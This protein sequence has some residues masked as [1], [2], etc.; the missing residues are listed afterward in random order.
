MNDVAIYLRKSRDEENL[1]LEV[2]RKHEK[3]L[4]D[5]ANTRGFRIVKIY[6]EVVSGESLK[7]RF[8]MQ[9]LLVAISEEA[10]DA[11]LVT[12]IS[13]LGRGDALEQ[14]IIQNAFA[15][16]NTRIIT[17]N[18]E[19]NPSDMDSEMIL[20]FES[21]LARQELRL[22][23]QRMRAGKSRSASLG[24]WANGIPP[25]G[26]TYNPQ[27]KHLEIN[28]EQ[29]EVVRQCVERCL[30]GVSSTKIA[31]GLNQ[32]GIKTNKGGLWHENSVRRMLVNPIYTGT[33]VFNKSVW[34]KRAMVR[35]LPQ[36]EW[37]VTDNAHPAIIPKKDQ[38]RVLATFSVR[39]IVPHAARASKH[40]L[41]GIVTCG[42]CGRTHSLQ[43]RVASVYDIKPCPRYDLT[44]G[45]RC[46][47]MSVNSNIILDEIYK[48][49]DVFEHELL[50]NKNAKTS[51]TKQLEKQLER[52]E[53]ELRKVQGTFERLQEMYEEGDINRATYIDRKEKRQAEIQTLQKDIGELARSINSV[54]M[55]DNNE[56]L[57]RI[58]ELKQRWN[59]SPSDEVNQL[60]HAILAKVSYVRTE[61]D[62]IENITIEYK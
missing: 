33:M 53:K 7:Q 52:K 35:E 20:S 23:K 2:L 15:E 14:A 34:K 62:T 50:T 11:V 39:A 32:Q 19:Y 51:P 13:R 36:S 56:R 29:A 10:Y 55:L 47:N 16:T 28:E 38:E 45:E 37:I 48:Q 30:Q 58:V 1:G 24:Q 3:E 54:S 21:L 59:S 43:K 61:R 8:A 12:E 46:P 60:L 41:S 42:I 27:T 17:P 4:T 26:Y 5:L 22:I 40:Q 6:R 25:Y 31:I 49:L 9:E 44:T 57:E 18:R